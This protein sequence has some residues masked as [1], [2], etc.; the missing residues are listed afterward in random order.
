MSQS[1]ERGNILPYVIIG[2]V[3]LGLLAG[4]LYLARYQARQA[5]DN[6]TTTPVT[7]NPTTSEDGS[8]D[9][10]DSQPQ[11]ATDESSDRSAN[12]EDRVPA[13]PEPTRDSSSDST[14]TDTSTDSAARTGEDDDRVPSTGPDN[15][16]AT[17]P[18][19]TM[20]AVVGVGVVA[21]ASVMYLRSARHVRRVR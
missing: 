1:S 17:G 11:P 9:K 7:L 4:S 8:R 13:D 12:Q 20:A 14:A 2:I 10:S 21:G 19:E 15:I 3:L 5:R 16:A 6:D 18:A